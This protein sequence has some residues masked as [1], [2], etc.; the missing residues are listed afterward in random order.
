[1]QGLEGRLPGES[2]FGR[3]GSRAVSPLLPFEPT[4][5][6]E[7]GAEGDDPAA[8]AQSLL[9]QNELVAEGNVVAAATIFAASVVLDALNALPTT[10]VVDV[11]VSLR[12]TSLV[13]VALVASPAVRPQV[14]FYQR[15]ASY[16]FLAIAA[17]SG[18]HQGGVNARIADALY[19]LLCG[20]AVIVIYGLTGPGGGQTGT[21]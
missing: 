19:T 16:A 17:W 6:S 7:K 13:L 8:E 3:R 15:A 1:M 2:P 10:L 12:T 11:P 21:R 4:E 5:P 9:N 14:R 20:W 18:L